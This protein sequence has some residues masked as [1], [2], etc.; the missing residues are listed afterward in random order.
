MR[1]RKHA[2][3]TLVELL[4]VITIIAML[5]AMVFPAFN[6]VVEEVRKVRC[7]TKLRDL[8]TACASYVQSHNDRYPGLL[9]KHKLRGGGSSNSSSG[10]FGGNNDDAN[11]VVTTWV[12]ELMPYM[13][14]PET[15][16]SWMRGYAESIVKPIDQLVCPSDPKEANDEQKLSYVANAGRDQDLFRTNT[17]NGVFFPWI[18][19]K[20][21][22]LKRKDKTLLFSENVQAFNWGDKRQG[23]GG[24]SLNDSYKPIEALV[25]T[26][27]A[28]NNEGRHNWNKYGSTTEEE[29]LSRSGA[30][31]VDKSYARP[32]SKH[33]GGANAVFC[34]GGSKFIRDGISYNVYV[35]LM[36]SNPDRADLGS[37]AGYILSDEDY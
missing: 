27:F 20:D 29:R 15:Y 3:F 33:S 28:W 14:E 12:V 9:N 19:V 23:S 17:A 18:K 22:N 24:G 11:T 2:G 32:S 7:A 34:G 10:G 21:S 35:H 31:T 13:Q 1:C 37:Y 30:G 16:E 5:M 36:I 25:W 6:Q 8:R 4:V 26:G